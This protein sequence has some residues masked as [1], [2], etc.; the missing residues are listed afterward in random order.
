MQAPGFSPTGHLGI[1]PLRDTK[2]DIFQGEVMGKFFKAIVSIISLAS[3]TSPL[4]SSSAL[5][6][7]TTPNSVGILII[8]SI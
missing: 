1:I 6:C 5:A 7:A 4:P 3:C 2:V 8:T